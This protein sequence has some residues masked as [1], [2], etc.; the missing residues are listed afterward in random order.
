MTQR[1]AS[2]VARYGAV[3]CPSDGLFV[4]ELDG[5]IWTRLNTSVLANVLALHVVVPRFS[6]TLRPEI[7]PQQVIQRTWSSM[8]LCSNLGPLIAISLGF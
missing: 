7:S 1:A 4:D 3:V 6:N 8:M 2:S 5:S